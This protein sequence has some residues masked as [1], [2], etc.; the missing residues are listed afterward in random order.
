MNAHAAVVRGF[1]GTG[2]LPTSYRFGSGLVSAA[3]VRIARRH[4]RLTRRPA[5]LDHALML[6]RYAHLG[7][8]RAQPRL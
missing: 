4:R 6:E 2:R 8:E 1:D 7:Q 3:L 5:N